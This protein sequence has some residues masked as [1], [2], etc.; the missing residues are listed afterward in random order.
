ML[1]RFTVG[2]HER[3]FLF[4]GPE[5][6]RMLRPGAHWVLGLG[7]TLQKVS[8]T[9]LVLE[10]AD[11]DV[12]LRDPDVWQ[13]V[14]VADLRDDERAL[15]WVDGRIHT[16]LGRGRAV[17]WKDVRDVKV[18]VVRVEPLRFEHP[19][20]AAILDTPGGKALLTDVTV[21]KGARGLVYVDERLDG[22]LGPGRYAFW[23]GVSRVSVD[24][25]DLR[26]VALDVAGQ[27]ILTSDKVTLRINL[28]ATYRVTDLRRAAEA[29]SNLGAAIYREL[30]LALREAVGTRTLDALLSAKDEIGR[31][32]QAVVAPKALALGAVLLGV[33]LKDVILPGEMKTLLNQ[34]IEA[35]KRA[36]ANLISR[37]E[38]TAATR[39]LLNTAKLIEQSPVLLRL[40]ELES[41]E[42]VAAHVGSIQI[43]GGGFEQLLG[44]LLPGGGDAVRGLLPGPDVK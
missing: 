15:V 36:Q 4:R 32:V 44:R 9:G 40:R 22:E 20:L 18:D 30:Q 1:R 27:E 8:T 34:V 39:S 11:L 31:G 26:E 23:K 14:V 43:V 35:E 3:A 42:R 2:R 25:V 28:A 12:L 29:T 38:E 7:R 16:V 37:R 21:P 5:Y 10:G 6:V 19:L 17:F 24:V 13:D 41:A 33:G